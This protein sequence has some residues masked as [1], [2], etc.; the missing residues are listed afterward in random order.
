MSLL[1]FYRDVS[2]FHHYKSQRLPVTL[3]LKYK[4]CSDNNQLLGS[5][6]DENRVVEETEAGG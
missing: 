2:H 4:Y 5:H 1:V 3:L 6:C